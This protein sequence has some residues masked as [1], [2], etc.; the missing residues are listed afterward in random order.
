MP[1]P[2][3]PKGKIERAHGFWQKRLP[4]LFV[5]ERIFTLPAANALLRSNYCSITTRRRSIVRSARLPKPHGI[6]P[7]EKKRSALRPTPSLPLSGPMSGASDPS[8]ESTPTAVSP[9]LHNASV[10]DRP[11][12]SKVIHCTPSQWRS[13]HSRRCPSPPW[14]AAH[15]SP[16]FPQPQNLSQL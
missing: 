14:L 11:P 1:Q 10:I 3:R 9:S 6:W 16:P 12:G 7:C 13:L 2:L 8:P 15:S 5:L 4:A